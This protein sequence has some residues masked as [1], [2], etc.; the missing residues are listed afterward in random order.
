[1]YF[2]AV[3]LKKYC[4]CVVLLCCASV[5]QAE[6]WQGTCVSVIDGDS[7]LVT[8]AEGKKEI[9]LHGIDAPEFDQA[10]GRQAR[11]CLR[12]LVL[13][14]K[15]TVESLDIDTYGRTVAKVYTRDGCV[16]E[17]L[18]ADGCAWVFTRF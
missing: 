17:R 12:D 11:E 8:H 15:V 16:N 10:F 1:M 14:K 4:I 6:T 18:I 9:R 7:L 3:S 5:V 2:L 13:Q